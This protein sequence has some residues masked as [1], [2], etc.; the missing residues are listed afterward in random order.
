ME[1]EEDVKTVTGKRKFKKGRE[2]EWEKKQKTESN[3]HTWK[4]A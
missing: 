3:K 1:R 4:E 2:I